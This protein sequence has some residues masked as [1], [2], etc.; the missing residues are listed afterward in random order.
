VSSSHEPQQHTTSHLAPPPPPPSNSAVELLQSIA[1]I[2]YESSDINDNVIGASAADTNAPPCQQ[3]Y[4]RGYH[5]ANQSLR[6]AE[7]WQALSQNQNEQAHLPMDTNVVGPVLNQHNEEQERHYRQQHQ[8][9]QI[10]RQHSAHP[11]RNR[12]DNSGGNIR[13]EAAN[14]GN[15]LDDEDDEDCDNFFMGVFTNDQ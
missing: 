15:A 7:D 9:Q 14:Q 5:E 10:H 11:N 4:R 2:G 1:G 13:H 12:Q 8:Q 3:D 6:F